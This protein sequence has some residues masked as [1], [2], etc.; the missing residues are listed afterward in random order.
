M[1]KDYK[2]A[3]LGIGGV[4]GYIGAK[5][6][7][8]YT[9]QGI[10]ISFLARGENA[11]A[12]EKN[13]LKLI[14]DNS[15]FS[16]Y[17]SVLTSDAR[18]LKS[19][20]LFI[21]CTKTYQVEEV[22]RS[23]L[24]GNENAKF[25]VLLNGVDASDKI[26]KIH[27]KISVLNGCIYLSSRRI[28]P[29]IVRQSGAVDQLYFGDDLIDIDEL[30]FIEKAFREARINAT[31]CD[32]IS[33]ICWEKYFFISS[34]AT[35]T[36]YMDLTIDQ[37]VGSD[38]NKTLLLELMKEL[39][40]TAEAKGINLAPDIIDRTIS[41]AMAMPDGA[42]SSMHTDFKKHNSTELESLTG[43]VVRLSEELGTYTPNYNKMYASLK[44]KA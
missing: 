39:K 27:P 41:K 19:I 38:S 24:P 35:L 43:Y 9:D 34:I 28:A 4:G 18:T 10:Q 31:L 3:I 16:V 37:I 11:G 33:L 23:V 7:S 17:P 25:L 40:L 15:E 14:T 5:L 26:K 22:I 32:N 44:N 21:V 36:S 6:A 29:G 42:T 13:G 30:R 2:I 12:I 1:T 8:V 20:D